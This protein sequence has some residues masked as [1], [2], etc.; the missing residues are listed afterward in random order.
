M[1]QAN[2]AANRGLPSNERHGQTTSTAQELAALLQHQDVATAALRARI[3]IVDDLPENLALIK[4][5]LDDRGYEVFAFPDGVSALRAAER[6]H[7]DLVLLDIT[8]PTMNGYTV[9]E[10][11]KQNSKMSDVPVIFLSALNDAEDK[12]KGFKVGGV[13]FITKPFQFEEVNARVATHLKLHQL[14]LRLEFQ[15][16]HLEELVEAKVKQ[17]ADSHIAT[18][19]AMAKLSENRDEDTG[20]HLERVQNYCRKLALELKENSVYASQISDNFPDLIYHASPLHD[21]GK[22][23]IPD[24]ILLKPGKLTPEE[25]EIMKTHAQIGADTLRSIDAAHHD[26][27]FL[28]MGIDIAGGHHERWNGLGYPNQLAGEAIPLSA[29]IMAVADVYDALRSERCY[30]KAMNHA[31]VMDII[32]SESGKHFDPV[33]VEALN[34]LEKEFNQICQNLK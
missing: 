23:A 8:M 10:R 16:R 1:E 34:A 32:R 12:V 18:I 11:L 3:M 5:M 17:L 13:D 6:I 21:V 15:N 25:F 7:P 24:S 4:N 33:L 26:N 20:K 31:E 27:A 9:C 29:R 14:Q 19:F 2:L 22:V 30:K 28:R